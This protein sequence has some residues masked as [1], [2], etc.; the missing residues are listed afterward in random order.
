MSK[1]EMLYGIGNGVESVSRYLSGMYYKIVE[2]G[3]IG[4]VL[5]CIM[6]IY[7]S[8]KMKNRFSIL[9]IFNII[10]AIFANTVTVHSMILTIAMLAAGFA[11]V[12]EDK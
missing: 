12:K 10:L 11:T 3:I 7:F 4:F 9:A 2:S 6:Y 8:I 1:Q 5:Y